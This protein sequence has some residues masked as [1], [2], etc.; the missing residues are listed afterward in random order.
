MP[1][2]IIICSSKPP[3]TIT[4]VPVNDFAIDFEEVVNMST[5][6]YY[7]CCGKSICQ[8]CKHSMQISGGNIWLCPYCKTDSTGKT[9][10]EAV[11]QIMKRVNVND[12]SAMCNL[13]IFY[14]NG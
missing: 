5:G 2:K 1:M 11:G 10:V 3:A 7:N 6:I 9:E 4:S 13:A 8:G 14:N 12:T